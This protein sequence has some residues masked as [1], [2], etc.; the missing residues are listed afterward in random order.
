MNN[1]I[2]TTPELDYIIGVMFG[3][4]LC[5][6]T[7]SVGLSG[8]TLAISYDGKRL[9]FTKTCLAH[10]A[11]DSGA[12][13][14]MAELADE[15]VPVI[16]EKNIP[17]LRSAGEPEL[18]DALVIT[19]KNGD[20]HINFDIFGGAFY[21][22][23]RLEE[24][25]KRAP[26][27]RARECPNPARILNNSVDGN[28]ENL[29]R[30]LGS[31]PAFSSHAFQNG[32]LHRPVVD[33]Y[34]EILWRC[35]Q[36]LW[37]GLRRRERQFEIMLTHD[38]DRPFESLFRPAWMVVR[39]FGND[40]LIRHD[41]KRACDRVGRWFQVKNGKLER[42]RFY[43]FDRIMDVSEASGCKDTFYFIPDC[44]GRTS[45][46]YD[47]AHPAIRAIIRR[48]QERG[49]EIGYHGSFDTY[50][51]AEKTKREVSRL[52]TIAGQEGVTQ[53]RWGGRQHYLRWSAPQTWRN[54]EAAGLNYDT[55]LSFTDA[56]GFRCGT[57]RP[58]T[59]F[60]VENRKQL[61][62]KEYPLAVMEGSVLGASYMGYSYNEALE[63]ILKLKEKCR[64][65]KGTFVLLWHNSS[66]EDDC[67]WNIY[68]SVLER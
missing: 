52:K 10:G 47:L 7:P 23:T 60:D 49:H 38:V 56:A 17:I 62:L 39:S 64:L 26:R 27:E 18:T 34:A 1:S 45:G 3:E 50:L 21:I 32:Y 68:R 59:V 37:P 42:D 31:F 15:L 25:H 19:D 41:L 28:V 9:I 43:N 14:Q 67:D 66:F 58:Y 8:D 55:T 46:D 54:Y 40:V 16:A 65:Y 33:E 35:M 5:T 6:E 61:K 20:I 22:L 24:I 29:W 30:A 13:L 36:A 2:L 12:R 53:T 63:Y 4:S 11:P 44:S 57:C 48:I 51:D